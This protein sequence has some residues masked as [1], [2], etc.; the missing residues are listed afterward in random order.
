M[1]VIWLKTYW[2]GCN[3]VSKYGK[4]H[5]MKDKKILFVVIYKTK[6]S[7][8]IKTECKIL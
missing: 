6:M 4:K 2:H 8:K 5:N 1:V 3:M 7:G